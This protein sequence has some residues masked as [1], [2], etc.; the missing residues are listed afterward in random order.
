MSG[1]GVRHT[2]NL[3]Y[4]CYMITLAMNSY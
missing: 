4:Q 1:Q 2:F 3:K